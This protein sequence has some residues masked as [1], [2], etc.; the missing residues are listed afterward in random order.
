MLKKTITIEATFGSDFQVM[1]AMRTF[2]QS[3]EA[4]AAMLA[5]RHQDNRVT[6]T[7]TDGTTEKN[8]G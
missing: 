5:E 4:W 1:P 7:V 3:L 2:E 8:P 6:W